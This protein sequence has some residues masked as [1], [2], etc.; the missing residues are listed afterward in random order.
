MKHVK[1]KSARH[2]HVVGYTN[3]TVADCAVLTWNLILSSPAAAP[4]LLSCGAPPDTSALPANTSGS[5][6]FH[7]KIQTEVSA[8]FTSAKIQVYSSS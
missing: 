6:P 1:A 5:A 3:S 7:W 4:G 8:S 2:R